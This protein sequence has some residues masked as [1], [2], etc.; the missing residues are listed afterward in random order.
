MAV[1]GGGHPAVPE[2]AAAIQTRAPRLRDWAPTLARVL[3]VELPEAE[4]FDLREATRLEPTRLEP[5]KG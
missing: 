5:A 4:G 3:N 1:V 2:I